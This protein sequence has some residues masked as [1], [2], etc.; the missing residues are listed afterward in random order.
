MRISRHL[1]TAVLCAEGGLQVLARDTGWTNHIEQ[2]TFHEGDAHGTVCH[3]VYVAGSNPAVNY[4]G[5][6][7]RLRYSQALAGGDRRPGFIRFEGVE[8][9]LPDDAFVIEAFLQLTANAQSTVD[10]T[11]WQ[12][13]T[14]GALVIAARG[15][16]FDE[17]TVTWNTMPGS[18]NS[19]ALGGRDQVWSHAF[20]DQLAS[21]G[22]VRANITPSVRAWVDRHRN[23]GHGYANQGFAM[24]IDPD[25][26]NNPSG[27]VSFFDSETADA[28]NRPQ[29][30]VRYLRPSSGYRA[31]LFQPAAQLT[32]HIV[33]VAVQDA[34]IRKSNQN[35]GWPNDYTSNYGG[36]T[37]W[38]AITALDPSAMLFRWTS[39]ALPVDH[40][41]VDARLRINGLSGW[42]KATSETGSW[43]VRQIHRPWLE[44]TG[45]VS[46]ALS[47]STSKE[48]VTWTNYNAV[49]GYPSQNLW[50][51]AGGTGAGDSTALFNL[52]CRTRDGEILAA[53]SGDTLLQVVQG[54]LEGGDN[55]GLM[56]RATADPRVSQYFGNLGGQH[57][58][59]YQSPGLLL[60]VKPA[61]GT[62]VTVR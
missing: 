9:L 54:W 26:A 51:A 52:G 5:Q 10:L 3:D 21:N 61:V 30:V 23:A 7:L 41:L 44:G 13:Y 53:D 14:Q 22:V 55:H 57:L 47:S 50:T 28:A 37:G 59:P 56:V 38:Y 18:V 49:A 58:D 62:L 16:T 1:W 2:M 8:A 12:K 29:L 31:H 45:V 15:H 46:Y 17:A 43:Q 27:T 60:I 48:G 39:L 24:N 6:G 19:F 32:S 25:W 20:Q 40:P 34:M 42:G 36:M 11:D 4:N 33:P 35:S